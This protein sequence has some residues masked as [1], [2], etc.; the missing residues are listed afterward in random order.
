MTVKELIEI[1]EEMPSDAGVRIEDNRYSR[2][3]VSFVYYDEYEED[4]IIE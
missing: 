1:L 4:V 2:S 3:N